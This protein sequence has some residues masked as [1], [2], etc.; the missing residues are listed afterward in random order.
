LRWSLPTLI[1]TVATLVIGVAAVR[2]YLAL[3]TAGT[4]GQMQVL[5]PR[6]VAANLVKYLVVA[7]PLILVILTNRGAFRS[8]EV[9]PLIFVTVVVVATAVGY[10]ALHLNMDNE[11]KL[12]L[13]STVVLGIPGGI[14]FGHLA[15]RCRGW[16]VVGVFLLLA[17]FL[18]PAFR[19][20]K[21]KLVQERAGRP[22]QEFVERG[23]SLHPTDSEADQLYRWVKESTGPRSAFIDRDLSICV[24]G[25]RAVFV[26]A[27]RPEL[28]ERKGFGPVDMILRQQ[29]GYPDELISMR[30]TIMDK[31]YGGKALSAR[32][33]GELRGLAGDVYVVLR[34]DGAADG[35]APGA[36]AAD[37]TCDLL[38]EAFASPSG[39]YKLYRMNLPQRP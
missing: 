34:A 25:E 2:P 1:A 7:L 17:A 36:A 35:A 18:F 8:A 27:G 16:R 14:A 39:K 32:E 22:S 37:L 33:L 38:T 21:M 20:V 19:F 3:L 28:Q 6:L 29:S 4:L 9:K 30:R 10:F 23:R 24:L 5:V 13:L 31:I 11:Y 15:G 12:L 26:P